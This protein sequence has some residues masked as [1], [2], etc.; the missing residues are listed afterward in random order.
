MED[1]MSWASI[2]VVPG[3]GLEWL[4]LMWFVLLPM[5]VAPAYIGW[6]LGRQSS[7]GARVGYAAV[8]GVFSWLGVLF[9]LLLRLT[10]RDAP[11]G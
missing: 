10:A 9:V 6:R 5:V 3:P 11:M 7:T 1:E 8:C 2:M 4:F